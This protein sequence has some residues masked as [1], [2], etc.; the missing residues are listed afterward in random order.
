MI[1]ILLKKRKPLILNKIKH[2]HCILYNLDSFKTGIIIQ[3]DKVAKKTNEI[4][5]DCSKSKFYIE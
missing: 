3:T 2:Y 1:K 5:S 4:F